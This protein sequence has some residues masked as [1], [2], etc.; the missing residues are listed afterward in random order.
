VVAVVV[1]VV[2][3][4]IVLEVELVAVLEFVSAEEEEKLILLIKKRFPISF[5]DSFSFFIVYCT[6]FVAFLFIFI[7]FHC[8]AWSKNFVNQ[9]GKA[10]N[11]LEEQKVSS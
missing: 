10:E 6:Y 9:N 2:I 5:F 1:I 7:L 8:S 11:F 3:V 4:V